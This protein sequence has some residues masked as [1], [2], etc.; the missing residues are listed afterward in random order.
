MSVIIDNVDFYD[1]FQ[2]Q[3][4]WSFSS[5]TPVTK[6]RAEA[7]AMIESGQYYGSRKMD[8]SWEMI[9]KDMDGNFW[10]RSR[11]ESVNGGYVNKSEWIPH[12]I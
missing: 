4:Y 8:G 10:A 3:K 2:P 11:T 7:K 5:S 12:I 9:V 6:R 1:K